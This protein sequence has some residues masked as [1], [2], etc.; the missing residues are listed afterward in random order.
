[1]SGDALQ[2][3][4]PLKDGGIRSVNFF[5]GRLLTS[6]DL[7]REQQARRDWDARLGLAIGDGV[8]F[9]LEAARD[10][11]LDAPLA[12]VL[13]VKAG[14]AVNR[15]GQ[16][17]RLGMDTSVALTRRFDAGTASACDC[18]FAN[19]NPL[20]DGTYVA[21]AGVYLLTIA[22]AQLSEGRAPTN[23]LDPGNVRC[24]TDVTV[25]GLQFRLLSISPQR[26]AGLDI[27]SPQFRNRLAYRCF[28]VEAR[29]AIVIDPW[30]SDPPSYG[31]VD[32]LR[33][34]GALSDCD[35]PLALVF[36]TASGL[37]FVDLWSV[38]RRLLGPDALGAQ[39]FVARD[40]RL[41]EAEAMCAQFQQHLGDLLAASATPASL[42]VKDHCRYL[43]PFGMVPL[44]S[45]PLRGF[46]DAAFFSGVPRRP[47]PGSGQSTPFMDGRQLGALRQIALAHAP[48]DLTAGEF[49]R[50]YRPSQNVQAALTGLPVQPV[51]VFASGLTPELAVA[52]FDMARADFSNFSDCCGG[53]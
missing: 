3:E 4:E 40:R 8:A 13:R 29:E 37:R 19:C 41:V 16:T 34:T 33:G 28:G 36:W 25:E 11:D 31:L 39:A 22:P 53:S 51:I 15:A 5:N 42:Q 32:D 12:P 43:P 6:K 26:Y 20:S 24:N 1:M 45:P 35:V 23:G 46:G 44:Q 9:G 18:V 10:A 50:V 47:V 38:R 52:R 14:L 21:G 49:V 48:I 30:R 27:A 7:S 17:L 2:L